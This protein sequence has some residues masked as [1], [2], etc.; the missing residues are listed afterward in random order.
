VRGALENASCHELGGVL[1]CSSKLATAPQSH[2][3]QTQTGQ[4]RPLA[5]TCCV[6]L[7]TQPCDKEILR[8]KTTNSEGWEVR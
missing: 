7:C 5:K 4:D 1:S 2:N 6:P 3:M 8:P